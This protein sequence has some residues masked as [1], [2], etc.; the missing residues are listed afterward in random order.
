MINRIAKLSSLPP[1]RTVLWRA[2]QALSSYLVNAIILIGSIFILEKH[3]SPEELSSFFVYFLVASIA[4]G[5]DPGTSKASITYA[6]GGAHF[7]AGAPL[8]FASSIKA[9]LLSPALIAVWLASLGAKSA[10]GDLAWVPI[11]AMIGFVATD[12][13]VAFD[14]RGQYTMAIWAKQGSLGLAALLPAT[15]LMLDM[16]L[17]SGIAAACFVRVVWLRLFWLKGMNQSRAPI[18]LT[19]HLF[20]RAWWHFLATSC[21]GALSASIDRIAALRLLDPASSNAYVLTYEILSKFWLINYLFAP[22]VFVQSARNGKHNPASKYAYFTILMAALPFIIFSMFFLEF[23]IPNSMRPLLEPVPLALF[24]LA[25][26]LTAINGILLAEAQ[27]LH[28]AKLAT[29][30]SAIGL[31]VSLI[32]FPICMVIWGING[33][34][35]AWV[36]K[37]T[38]EFLI[39]IKIKR[40]IQTVKLGQ[41]G[42]HEKSD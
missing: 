5:L 14:A 17:S 15:A 6:E 19:D 35:L 11:I 7:E 4:A 27:A 30:S 25:I 21:L 13:R 8:L 1:Q 9:I 38:S 16:S 33:L 36:I 41:I 39:F 22:I 37:S 3:L 20:R 42:N 2:F 34:F 26:V 24:A 29:Q 12:M 10:M 18:S 40:N 28:F 31:I 23:L 32:A